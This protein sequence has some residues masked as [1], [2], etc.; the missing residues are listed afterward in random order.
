MRNII[1][2]QIYKGENCYVAEGLN[3]SVVTQ[4]K[5]LNEVVKNLKEA[6]ELHLE[7]EDLSILDFSKQPEVVVNF[8]LSDLQYA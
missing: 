1:Y 6:V 7:G 5:D 2:V 3:L 8:E 4:G